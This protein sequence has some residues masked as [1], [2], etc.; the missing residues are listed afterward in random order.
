MS[1]QKLDNP[2]DDIR[3]G[4]KLLTATVIFRRQRQLQAGAHPRVDPQHHAFT[5]IATMEVAAGLVS[6]H[7]DGVPEPDVIR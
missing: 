5:R 3:Y 4:D 1:S 7:H 6:W 2:A